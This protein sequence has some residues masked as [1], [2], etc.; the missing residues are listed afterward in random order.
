M[1]YS[2]KAQGKIDRALFPR[3]RKAW[4][5]VKSFGGDHAVELG[6]YA[7]SALLAALQQYVPATA[8]AGATL[9][10]QGAKNQNQM[11]KE[12][13]KQKMEFQERQSATAMQ[14]RRADMEVAGLNPAMMYSVGGAQAQSGSSPDLVN[15]LA[16]AAST[17][18]GLKSLQASINKTKQEAR[19]VE[20][21]NMIKEPQAETVNAVYHTAKDAI[22]GK[23]LYGRRQR[24]FR[25]SKPHTMGAG[26][27]SGKS[28]MTEY[29]L[30]KGLN[31][32]DANW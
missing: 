3:L 16:G 8:L 15:E 13:S 7:G 22:T 26:S 21:D 14:T 10:Y 11:M 4:E 30:S 1:A 17:A 9:S 24:D 28:L 31:F 18:L 29:N 12:M 19:S 23:N 2:K 6:G 32:S 5:N 20:L 25:R 27:T